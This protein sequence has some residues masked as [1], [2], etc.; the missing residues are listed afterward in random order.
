MSATQLPTTS[1]A[2]LITGTNGVDS[3]EQTTVPVPALDAYE[4][5]VRFG[6]VSLNFRDLAIAKGQ[7]PFHTALPVVAVSD[8]GGAVVAVGAKVRGLA[9]GDVVA[10]LFH[11]GHQF[12]A[13]DAASMRTGL[14]GALDGALREFAVFEAAGLVKAPAGWTCAQ[15]ATLPVA[16][17][18]AWNAL[19]GGAR[20]LRA[21]DAVLVQGSGGVSVFALQ[22]A[23]AAG[24]FVCA[25]TSSAAKAARLTALGADVVLNYRTTPAWGLAARAAAPHGEGYDF[26]VEVGKWARCGEACGLC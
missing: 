14:G 18:T 9:P 19:Y 2:W 17:L 11:Q 24:A 22:L 10:T 12:G 16:A 13:L 4:V 6:A 25:T 5:L 15:A 26:I 7:Y 23:K 20:A 3:L 1:K 21:G 8:G